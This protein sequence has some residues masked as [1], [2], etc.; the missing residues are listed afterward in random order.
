MGDPRFSMDYVKPKQS[1]AVETEQRFLDALEHCLSFKS[2]RETTIQDI[3]EAAGLH[4]GAF[5]KRFKTKEM[6]LFQLYARY[7][8]RA[9]EVLKDILSRLGG[10]ESLEELTV[11]MSETLE[12]IQRRDFSANRAMNEVFLVNLATDPYTVEIFKETVEVM[13]AAQ[14]HFLAPGSYSDTGAFA[15]TQILVSAN[16]FY[17][18]HAMPALPKN[19]RLRHRL[20]GRWMVQAATLTPGAAEGG[21]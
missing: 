20:I 2:Y 19:P 3:A 15:A 8:D 12:R 21:I 9:S 13:R 1:R 14:R 16:Y 7:K 10:F 4:R 17:V 6:A 11:H 5:I 18:L